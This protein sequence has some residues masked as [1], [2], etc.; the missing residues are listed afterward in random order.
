MFEDAV[1]VTMVV[2]VLL[3]LEFREV[4]EERVDTFI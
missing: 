4:L 2:K 1:V 3:P